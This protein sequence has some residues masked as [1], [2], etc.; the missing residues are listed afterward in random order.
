MDFKKDISDIL[1]DAETLLNRLI[2][3]PTIYQE[4]E[5]NTPFGLAGTFLFVEA[6]RKRRIFCF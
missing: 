5:E 1:I 2:S 3:Y 4:N 6:S